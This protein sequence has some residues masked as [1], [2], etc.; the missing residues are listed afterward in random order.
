MKNIFEY[1]D[2]YMLNF[3]QIKNILAPSAA[4]KS[5]EWK[6]CKLDLKK[7]TETQ[8][9]IIQGNNASSTYTDIC[10]YMYH[11]LICLMKEWTK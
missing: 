10:V 8:L 5:K 4:D 1:N 3:D 6:S 9:K 7:C 11:C 2:L